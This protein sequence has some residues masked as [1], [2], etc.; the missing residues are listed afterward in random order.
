MKKVLW[1]TVLTFVGIWIYQT[2]QEDDARI[3]AATSPSE[4]VRLKLNDTD[5]QVKEKDG[6]LDIVYFTE[7]VTVWHLTKGF[8][9][10][11][12]Y[13]VPAVFEKFPSIQSVHIKLETNFIDGQAKEIRAP[14][15]KATFTRDNSNSIQWDS[16]LL[17][18]IPK[19]ADGF[20][21]HPNL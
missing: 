1:V 4:F 15:F 9:G 14:A 12:R 10:D 2:A 16:I 18:N 3:E 20:W 21:K 7:T 8:Y 11:V 13:T 19:L 17:D 5:A 6:E